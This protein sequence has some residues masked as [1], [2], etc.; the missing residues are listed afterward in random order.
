MS[1]S[2][3]KGRNGKDLYTKWLSDTGRK[4]VWVAQ[5]LGAS[6]ACVST[7]RSGKTRPSLEMADKL[8]ELTDGAVPAEA[9]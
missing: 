3:K 4:G 1:T 8:E 5:Q 2:T 7:W 9:W 6:E